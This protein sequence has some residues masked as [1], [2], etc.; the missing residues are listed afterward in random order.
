MLNYLNSLY[1][2]IKNNYITIFKGYFRKYLTI[3][4]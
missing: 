1:T 3:R 2:Y 4:S